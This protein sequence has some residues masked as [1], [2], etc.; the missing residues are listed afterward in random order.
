MAKNR[1]KPGIKRGKLSPKAYIRKVARKLPIYECR[2][3]NNWAEEPKTQVFVARQ[4]QQGDLLV[5]FFL[6]DRWCL[7]VKDAFYK[8][9][10]SI[11]EYEEMVESMDNNIKESY[12]PATAFV[13]CDPQLAFNLIYGAVEYAEDLGF[14][15]AKEFAIVEYILDD[16][17]EV[18]YMEIE[19]GKD[20]QPFYEYFLDD[21]VEKI[22]ATLEKN[23]G[24]GNYGY[25]IGI[26]PSSQYDDWEDED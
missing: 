26:D 17:D 10:L 13:K 24:K 20:G 6:V 14:A 23:V 15:P 16:V 1:K 5:G 12:G 4:R 18:E 2:I 21:N 19:F 3:Y 11:F 7:G 8:V 25:T 9:N 22:L